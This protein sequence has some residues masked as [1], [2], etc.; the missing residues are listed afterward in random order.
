MFSSN[1][2]IRRIIEFS[3]EAKV[4][5]FALSVLFLICRAEKKEATERLFKEGVLDA[6]W[7]IFNQ[8]PARTS[9]VTIINSLLNLGFEEIEI[10]TIVGHNAWRIVIEGLS[11][12]NSVLFVQCS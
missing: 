9:Q 1:R 2:F 5:R 12:D 10:R 4:Q 8:E 11:S 7:E 3:R 6:F